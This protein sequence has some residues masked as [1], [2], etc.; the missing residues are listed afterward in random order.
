MK[1]IA[2][3][4]LF[5]GIAVVLLYFSFREIKWSDFWTDLKVADYKWILLSMGCGALAFWVRGMRWRLLI[6]GAGYRVGKWNAFDAVNIAY[7]TNF[8]LPRAGEVARCGVLAKTAGV[9]FDAL[10]GTVVLERTFDTLCLMV[11]TALVIAL[12]WG[13]FG[14]FMEQQLWNPLLHTLNEKTVFLVAILSALVLLFVLILVYRKRLQKVALFKKVYDLAAG[15][16]RG[17]KSG[18][19]MRQKTP[20][21]GYTLA[22][23]FLYWATCWCTIRAFPT[24][25]T[26]NPLDALFLMV[27]GSLGWVVPVQ[28]G[29]G[30]YHFIVSLALT[31]VYAISQTQSIVFA[32]ISH[33]SQAVTMILFGII[34]LI[35]FGLEKRA[36]PAATAPQPPPSHCELPAA[37]PIK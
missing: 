2:S 26:L 13:V 21:M 17:L 33:E 4:I 30:A 20:F 6:R 9:P 36:V 19:K 11:I 23:W 35:R 25:A 1:K 5:L 22:L 7:I 16:L 8:A 28:G 27:V 37:S 14:V 34:S 10:L 15:V 12:Q 18:F 29:I 31:S 3:Y 24:A 32:T